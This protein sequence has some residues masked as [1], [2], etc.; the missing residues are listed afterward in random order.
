MAGARIYPAKSD[1]VYIPSQTG[2]ATAAWYGENATL[3]AS[4]LTFG[5]LAINIR[6]LGA[7]EYISNELLADSSPAAD[8]LVKEDLANVIALM[9]DKTYLMSNGVAPNFANAPI[10]FAS[11]PGTSGVT[12]TNDAG[13][14]GALVIADLF[15]FKLALMQ[16]NVPFDASMAWFC[17]PRTWDE[18]AQFKDLALRYQLE[19]LTGGNVSQYPAYGN[20]PEGEEGSIKGSV[21]GRLL[22]YPVYV[23]ANI[24]DTNT[25]G[26]VATASYLFFARMND[27][28]IAERA[29]LELMASNVAGTAF[30]SDQTW[31]RGIMRE[32]L[33][34]RHA[35]AV[36]VAGGLL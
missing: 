6:K 29:G 26:N 2:G 35:P 18:I 25:W 22:G 7:L 31:V 8:Q 33:G 11:Y 20:Y 19:S 27:V 28:F 12:I 4:N 30:A 24:A 10:G 21:Q 16:A 3:T 9:E 5:Q 32:G 34:I 23:T 1:I 14:G 17:S 15:K 13:N 36:A